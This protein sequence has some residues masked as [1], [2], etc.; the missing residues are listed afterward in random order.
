MQETGF[1]PKRLAEQLGVSTTT[2]R[3]YEELGLIPDVP[4]TD[5]RR[6]LYTGPHFLAFTAIRKLLKGYGVPVVYEAMQLQKAGR[7][8]EALWLFNREQFNMQEEKRRVEE[9]LMMIRKSDFS[10]FG[11]VTIKDS[12]TIGEVAEL[13]GV[14]PSAIRFWEQEGLFQSKRNEDNGYRLYTQAE[15]RSIIVISSLRKTVYFIDHM[16]Q[17]LHD[18]DNRSFAKVERSFRLALQKLDE[19]LMLQCQGIAAFMAYTAAGEP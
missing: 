4:R 1:T 10:L 14:N 9:M 17:L 18:L 2:L 13:A 11:N 5:S 15:L 7:T 12:M 19:Q 8:V 16:K 3:R 6:R